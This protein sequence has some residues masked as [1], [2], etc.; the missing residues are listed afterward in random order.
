MNPLQVGEVI[1][2]F[3]GGAFG[4]DSYKCRRVEAIGA[5]WAVTRNTVGDV[6]C[7]TGRSLRIAI[8]EKSNRSYCDAEC[9]GR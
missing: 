2:G 9:A 4:R 7:V 5:D 3:C 1:H 6:E 8:Q